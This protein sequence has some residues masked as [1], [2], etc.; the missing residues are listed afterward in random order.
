[1]LDLESHGGLEEQHRFS[2]FLKPKQ[3]TFVLGGHVVT[4]NIL[5]TR[6]P[7]WLLDFAEALARVMGGALYSIDLVGQVGEKSC[8]GPTPKTPTTQGGSRQNPKP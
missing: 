1:M 8:K 5:E 4:S 7:L 3:K 2:F 6:S